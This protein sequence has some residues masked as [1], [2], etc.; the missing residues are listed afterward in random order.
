MAALSKRDT[1]IVG[2]RSFLLLW[3]GNAATQVGLNGVRVA[4][5]LLAL[6][7]SGS[8]VLSSCIA[9]AM[10]V[11]G[12][13]FQIPAGHAADFMDR[14]RVLVMCQRIGLMATLLAGVVVVLRPPVVWLPLLAVAAFVEGTA[15]VFFG[16]SELAMVRDM[17]TVAQRPAAFSFLEV[18]QPMSALVGRALGGA[19][20]SVARSL[21]FL[22]NAVS[23]LYCLW[24][25][26]ALRGKIPPQQGDGGVKRDRVWGWNRAW[27]GL[28][29]MS[30][31]P[32]LRRSTFVIATTNAVFQ[33][34]LLLITLDIRQTGRSLVTIGVVLSATGLGGVL[35]VLP[36]AWLANRFSIRTVL[37]WSL[38]AWTA[39]LVPIALHG[40]PVVLA[41]C[42]AG[43]GAVGAA[44]NVALTLY[45]VRVTPDHLLGRVLGV[46]ALVGNAGSAAGSLVAG[47]ALWIF[48]TA[49]TGW[50]LVAV[51]V[52]LV[53]AA[54]RLHEPETSPAQASDASHGE[55]WIA[56]L[57][58][59]DQRRSP[60][61]PRHSWRGR[62]GI[63]PSSRGRGIGGFR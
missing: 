8:P 32:F 48:G 61:T 43:I 46:I 53:R 47:F 62:M 21:P 55:N 6:I 29:I 44:S 38:C 22:A 59:D 11:P 52:V 17:V 41:S 2:N 49:V 27:A 12:L 42:W 60:P 39:L 63:E 56:R 18:E 37:T 57:A 50:M 9:F 40:N 34:V 14:R 16:I 15:H 45:R 24:T 25:L 7:L 1:S 28:R 10:L 31:E 51:L 35:G 54:S 3:S 58:V 13:L 30:A 26:S 5:P 20:L 23:Y 4:Y 36:A 33:V 19:A